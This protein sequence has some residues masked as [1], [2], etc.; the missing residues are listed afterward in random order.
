MFNLP[1]LDRR[2]IHLNNLR[3]LAGGRHRQQDDWASTKSDIS[4]RSLSHTHPHMHDNV[5]TY[6][7]SPN[8]RP[9][10][11]E[12][13]EIS[14][15]GT[16]V[17]ANRCHTLIYIHLQFGFF[18]QVWLRFSHFTHLCFLCH[19]LFVHLVRCLLVILSCTAL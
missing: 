4:N 8:N 15:S 9:Q 6:Q 10:N 5:F 11:C 13:Q 3:S 17:T 14:H 1:K 2:Q 7:S 16:N 12:V 18:F 19:C